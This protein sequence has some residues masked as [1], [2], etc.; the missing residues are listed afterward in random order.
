MS[1][2]CQRGSREGRQTREE[3]I[4]RNCH[5]KERKR[6]DKK[7]RNGQGSTTTKQTQGERFIIIKLT[8]KYKQALNYAVRSISQEGGGRSGYR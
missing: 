8:M 5:G 3:E 6:K 1:C 2:K 7:G 4:A